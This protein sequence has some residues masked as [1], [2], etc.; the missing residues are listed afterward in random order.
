VHPL[1]K[2]INES[3]LSG[4]KETV[5]PSQGIIM[6]INSKVRSRESNNNEV[7]GT[8]ILL[9]TRENEFRGK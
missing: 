9:S 6:V 5:K 3:K 4:L 8:N 1:A 2:G 7:L